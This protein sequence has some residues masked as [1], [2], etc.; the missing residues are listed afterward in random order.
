MSID[1]DRVLD[2]DPVDDALAVMEPERYRRRF[3]MQDLDR[4]WLPCD[5]DCCSCRVLF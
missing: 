3:Q 5:P 1:W 2:Y 4:P